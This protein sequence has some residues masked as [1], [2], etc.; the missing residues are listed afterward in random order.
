MIATMPTSER[1]QMARAE[2]AR[3]IVAIDRYQGMLE[4][5]YGLIGVLE[6]KEQGERLGV[7][8]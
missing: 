2:A 4:A 6:E 7:T 5:Q 1:L 3:L 8:L